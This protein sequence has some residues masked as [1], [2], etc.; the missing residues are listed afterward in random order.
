MKDLLFIVLFFLFLIV[1]SPSSVFAQE[2]NSS[3]SAK[4]AAGG[5]NELFWPLSAG[6]TMDDSFYFLKLWKEDIR[7]IFIFGEAQKAD[8]EVM[9][10]TKRILEA[11]K[12]LKSGKDELAT[13]TLEKALN[14]LTLARGKF[15]KATKAGNEF[16]LV[17][18]NLTNQ[19]VNLNGF[20]PTLAA[21][22]KG[23]SKVQSD[24][25]KEIAEKFLGDV[26]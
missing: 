4:L 23:D 10:S 21:S 16:Q 20:L 18:A 8:Y 19:L 5:S 12:L 14:Q 9:L 2:E 17:K 11:E 13:K 25:T 6:K 7:G 26:R 15:S 3:I 1:F 22:T 24:K